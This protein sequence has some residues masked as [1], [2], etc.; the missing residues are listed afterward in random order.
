MML[1]LIPEN[2][3]RRNVVA[4]AEPARNAQH[5]KLRNPLR[6]SI[7]RLT[8]HR[9]ATAACQLERVRSFPVAIRPRRSQN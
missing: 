2:S 8:C 3:P 7:N 5:L 1:N 9:S 6:F 4:V